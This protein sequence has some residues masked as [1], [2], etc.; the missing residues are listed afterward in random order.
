MGPCLG[1]LVH[2]SV[3]Q[4][5]FASEPSREGL[6]GRISI[7]GAYH[8][9]LQ[10][11]QQRKA[12][13]SE[14]CCL[15][16]ITQRCQLDPYFLGLPRTKL[17]GF[18]LGLAHRYEDFD[19]PPHFSVSQVME[20][21]QAQK[22]TPTPNI[23]SDVGSCAGRTK[24]VPWDSERSLTAL[25]EAAGVCLAQFSVNSTRCLLSGE[26]CL[27]QEQKILIWISLL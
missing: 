5:H 20:Q 18:V 15:Q 12:H 11:I 26:E 19:E 14:T 21:R 3:V 8:L 10:S 13:P 17:G 2:K 27:G 7:S 6:Q 23:R 4:R 16:D 25:P 1:S 22:L 24:C 9:L